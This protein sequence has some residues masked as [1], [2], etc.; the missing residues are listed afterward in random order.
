MLADRPDCRDCNSE[1][2]V[3]TAAA[4]ATAEQQSGG[5][6]KMKE[7]PKSWEP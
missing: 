4:A 2:A 1:I 3:C 5:G 6:S 7:E